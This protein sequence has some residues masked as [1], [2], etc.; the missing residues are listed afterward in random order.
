MPV[1]TRGANANVHPGDV[2]RKAQQ[3]RRTKE[4]IAEDK[5]KAKA[6][7]NAARQEVATKHRAVIST[8]MALKSSVEREEEAIRAQAN[9]PDLQYCSPSATWRA[10]T[11][12]LPV[13]V[14][15][16]TVMT[17]DSAG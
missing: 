10:L 7:A 16:A 6:E 14:R 1:I 12:G 4:E 5:A 13:R 11:Q 2:V 15:K 8:I 9:R 17:Y 3:N